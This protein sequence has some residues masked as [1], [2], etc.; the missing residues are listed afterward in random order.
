M[1][2]AR[3]GRHRSL[4]TLSRL[5]PFPL[6]EAAAPGAQRTRRVNPE[7]GT[8]GRSLA[9]RE[10]LPTTPAFPPLSCM[11][12]HLGAPGSARWAAA[13]GRLTPPARTGSPAK[14]T[15]GRC[16]PSRLGQQH[17]EPRG[18]TGKRGA[19][20]SAPS[21]RSPEETDGDGEP[22]LLFPATTRAGFPHR[23]LQG[24]VPKRSWLRDQV[25][26]LNLSR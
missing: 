8:P 5:L 10:G 24:Q 25:S 22:W 1:G 11:Q 6:K 12:Q 2:P 7:P 18:K 23:A 26:L 17:E 21:A 20:R 9:P 13:G 4:V 14:G 16:G 19:S 15:A 3:P